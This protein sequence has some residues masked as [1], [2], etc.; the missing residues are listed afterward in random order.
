LALPWFSPAHG[1]SFARAKRKKLPSPDEQSLDPFVE[2]NAAH[3][4]RQHFERLE[5]TPDVL[6][7]DRDYPMSR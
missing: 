2:R 6:V 3:G 4:A 7:P 1:I 5:H